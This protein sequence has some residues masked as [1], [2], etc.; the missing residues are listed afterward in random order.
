ML[1]WTIYL[2][3][4]GVAVLMFVPRGNANAARIVAL[5]TALLGFVVAL[6]GV[7][8]GST[9]VETLCDASWVRTASA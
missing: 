7:V 5:L 6:A 4:L 1:D 2:S 3:F 9:G 8:K